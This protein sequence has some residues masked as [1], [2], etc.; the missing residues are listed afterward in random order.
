MLGRLYQPWDQVM[1]SEVINDLV[2]ERD[3]YLEDVGVELI[4]RLATNRRTG[5]QVRKVMIVNRQHID[6]RSNRAFFE[7]R[8][9][10]VYIDKLVAGFQSQRITRQLAEFFVPTTKVGGLYTREQVTIEVRAGLV[11]VSPPDGKRK[12]APGV[13][14]SQ[15]YCIGL[16]IPGIGEKTIF[17]F[18]SSTVR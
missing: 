7:E 1:T 10:L 17:D 14:I 15:R 12:R 8:P 9:A 13:N 4:Q 3:E 18:N 5:P 16:N 2:P 11:V 6:G